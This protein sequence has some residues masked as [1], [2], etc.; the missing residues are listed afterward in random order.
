[1]LSVDLQLLKLARR[2]LL[3]G[4]GACSNGVALDCRVVISHSSERRL[5]TIRVI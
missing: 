5:M 2:S 3:H 4:G 1:M